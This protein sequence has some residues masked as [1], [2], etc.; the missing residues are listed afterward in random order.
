MEHKLRVNAK[1][2]CKP[3]AARILLAILRKL[4]AK[5]NQHSIQPS[6]HVGRVVDLRLEYRNPCHQDR[7]SLLV[8]QLANHRRARLR[9]VACDRRDPQ[10][11][12]A[13]RMLVVRDKLDETT[14]V[15]RHR[16][17]T[18]TG[19]GDDLEVYAD[20]CAR[21]NHTKLP[22]ACLAD[23]DLRL[24]DR[25]TLFVC[26]DGMANHARDLELLRRLDIEGGIESHDEVTFWVLCEEAEEGLFEDG[27]GKRIG[28]DD[29]TV[30]AIRER[31]HFKEADLVEAASEEVDGVATRGGA[32]GQGF[33]V[34]Q[35]RVSEGGPSG[36]SDEPSLSACSA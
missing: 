16:S 22:G 25:P 8:E 3:E 10:A 34:L 15:R 1:F 12:L 23:P 2:F 32:F 28:N 33:E 19:L 30:C 24:A 26:G 31:L 4:L 5:P 36:G 11:E 29:C 35:V 27:G 7:S 9:K 13:G 17:A 14:L 20:G 6:E 18:R 21:G